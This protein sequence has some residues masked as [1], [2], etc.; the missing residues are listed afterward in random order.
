MIKKKKR[1]K[2]NSINNSKPHHCPLVF[3]IQ[4]QLGDKI[5]FTENAAFERPQTP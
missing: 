4:K 2:E 3:G 1:K 5:D